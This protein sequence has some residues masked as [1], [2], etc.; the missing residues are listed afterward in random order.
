MRLRRLDTA[1]ICCTEGRVEFLHWKFVFLFSNNSG[2]SSVC[3]GRLV[4]RRNYAGIDTGEQP[5]KMMMFRR[6]ATRVGAV[7]LCSAALC[8][9]PMMAQG[10]GG[11]G[12]MM[13][14]PD[15]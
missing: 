14:T 10:S 12:R 2:R 6:Y 4:R 8:A 3:S 7:A 1:A 15:Q 13:M 11:G 9:V 5:M